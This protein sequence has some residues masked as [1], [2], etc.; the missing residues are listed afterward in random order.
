MKIIGQY[1]SSGELIPYVEP[2][3]VTQFGNTLRD[4]DGLVL[5][6]KDNY[7]D[8]VSPSLYRVGV[9]SKMEVVVDRTNT[10][11]ARYGGKRRE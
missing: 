8:W 7:G 9:K 11:K 5:A 6:I 1:S 4:V 10:A 2:Q 3:E